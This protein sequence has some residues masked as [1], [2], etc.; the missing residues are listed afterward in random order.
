[1]NHRLFVAASLCLAAAIPAGLSAQ[2]STST[3]SW[4]F[5]LAFGD[6]ARVQS[7]GL[8]NI[9]AY[10]SSKRLLLGYGLRFAY[11]NGDEIRHYSAGGSGSD[12]L[13]VKPVGIIS[14]NFNVQGGFKFS[15]DIEIG[16]NIDVIGISY[17]PKRTADFR[18]GTVGISS[19]A[20][21]AEPTWGNLFLFGSDRGTLNSEVF[22]GY[23]INSNYKIKLGYSRGWTE[24]Y[25]P[26]VI[27]GDDRT[28]RAGSDMFLLG[29]RY[30]P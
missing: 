30:T 7:V 3:M 18:S 1:M 29:V 5:G 4:D 13:K 28:F 26:N 16:A 20:Q 25:T 12:K 22:L 9:K 23:T 15:D 6:I 10:T 2:A 27:I 19:G 11:S 8:V 24:Y 14:A 17:G 21:G